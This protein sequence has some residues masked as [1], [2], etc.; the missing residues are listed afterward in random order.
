MMWNHH[1]A[2]KKGAN[3]EGKRQRNATRSFENPNIKPEGNMNKR[4]KDALT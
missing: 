1:Q 4:L 2:Q 3:M